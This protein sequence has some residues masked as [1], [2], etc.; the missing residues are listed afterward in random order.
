MVMVR[1]AG[2]KRSVRLMPSADSILWGATVTRIFWAAQVR[3]MIAPSGFN[4][5]AAHIGFNI[6]FSIR[7]GVAASRP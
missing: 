3:G 7:D 1:L 2:C 5:L 4:T 6:R